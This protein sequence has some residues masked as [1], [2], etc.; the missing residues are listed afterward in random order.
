LALLKPDFYVTVKEGWNDGYQQSPEYK[1]VT[2]YGGQVE[3]V[4][5]QSPFIST[6]QILK[7]SVSSHLNDVLQEFLNA[8]RQPL[9]EK[10]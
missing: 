1:T 5:R 9:Q 4:E 7:R 6:T 3:L 8:S 10:S 2:E